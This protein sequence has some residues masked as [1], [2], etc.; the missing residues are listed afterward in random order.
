MDGAGAR[1]D[2]H[3]PAHAGQIRPQGHR[4]GARPWPSKPVVIMMT[5]Y[6]N[7][8]TAVEAMKRGAFDFLT[9][10]V[11][12]EK[13]E[14]L[15]QRALKT[16]TL[17]VEVKQLHER[18]DEKFSFEG[19]VGNSQKLRDVI[20]R[21][22]LVAPSQGHHPHRGRD[23][24]GQG[25][26]RAGHPPGQS[27][28]AGA[29]HRG[30]LRGAAAD[31]CWK[32]SSSA[33]SAARS[34]A[35]P[36]GASAASRRPNGGT[37]FLDEIGEISPATQVKLLRFLETKSHRAH[38]RH[39][40]DPARRAPGRGHQQE[41]RADGARTAHSAR[42]CFSGSTSC[43]SRCRRCASAPRMCRCCS[44]I[45]SSFSARRTTCRR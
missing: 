33:T 36:S 38:R 8:E 12:L 18:L 35:R 11:N 30:A 4:Q 15:I 25:A 32:A 7:I 21:V 20:E 6:G 34:P 28:G 40:A 45:T 22:K 13:L 14:I 16:K 2:R 5:A 41:S 37:L 43:A 26:D 10:P 3:R 17:E 42:T 29:V 24:L 39:E 1:R 9:K 31:A 44:T 27:A 23:G 19:I